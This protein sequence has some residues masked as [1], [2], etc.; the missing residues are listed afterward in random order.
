VERLHDLVQLSTANG[1][2]RARLQLKPADLGSVDVRLRATAN[3]VV[4]T[5]TVHEAAAL[6]AVA[7]AGADLRDALAQRGVVLHQLDVSLAADG[8]GTQ[9]GTGASAQQREP[10]AARRG[11]RA[12]GALDDD[13]ELDPVADPTTST[14]TTL[15]PGALVDVQA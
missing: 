11:A 2:A 8:S 13:D 1:V 10:H 12:A 7:Q 3:G 6:P 15:A 14:T 4:A 5:V 9:T